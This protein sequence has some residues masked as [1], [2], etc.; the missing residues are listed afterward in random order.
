VAEGTYAEAITIGGKAVRLEG[1]CPQKVVLTSPEASPPCP[2]AGL[3]IVNG[4]D[5]TTIQGVTLTGSGFGVLLSGAADVTFRQV[6]VR[7]NPEGGI[8]ADSSLGDT[9]T[10]VAESLVERNGKQG[11]RAGSASLVLESSVV[12]ETLPDAGSQLF[13]HGLILSSCAPVTGST[14]CVPRPRRPAH[15]RRSVIEGNR[16]AGVQSVDTEV[17]IED[18]VIRNTLPEEASGAFG[19][20]FSS[21]MYCP[22]EGCTA[23][24]VEDLTLRHVFID[25]STAMGIVA[26]GHRLDIADTVVRDTTSAPGDGLFGDGIGLLSPFSG[27]PSAIVGTHIIRSA[28]AGLSIFGSHASVRDVRITCAPIEIALDP[29]QGVDPVLEDGGNNLC[30]CPVADGPCKA[31]SAGLEPPTPLE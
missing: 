4:A 16:V 29:N 28:R 12:R 30:G 11:V 23:D 26:T 7:D 15:V 17:T 8:D 24:L 14:G 2:L 31:A 10:T 1:V 22:P 9:S 5:G 19:Y 20:G 13:G 21:Y 27:T 6:H 25:S 3:C 18:T